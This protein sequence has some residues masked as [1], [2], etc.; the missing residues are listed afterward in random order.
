MTM[1]PARFE[2]LRPVY[3]LIPIVRELS[4]DTLTP[5]A[6]FAALVRG[7]ED[8]FLLESVER[9]ESLG[10]YSFLG[11]TP[12]KTMTFARGMS[13]P[14]PLL[15]E[16]LVPLRVYD[17]ESLPP[18]F[19]GAVGYFGYGAAGWSE[20]LPD[21]HASSDV[22]DA[23]LLF[24]DHVIAFDHLRQRLF[25]IANIFTNDPAPAAELLTLAKHRIDEIVHLLRAAKPD[26]IPLPFDAPAVDFAAATTRERFVEIVSKAREEITAG[27]IF[28]VVLSQSWSAPYP[29]SE[30][31]ILYRALR[32]V[33]PSPYMFLL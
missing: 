5:V 26:L 14:V 32:A 7:S 12:R 21:R 16:E 15:R 3:D 31:L 17:E 20:R 13:V 27:E 23:K 22:P 10:R 8:S 25:V 29:A 1:T 18:F 33:N 4:A 2:E 11:V 6:A 19:G 24:F 9:G 28:Q 30:A